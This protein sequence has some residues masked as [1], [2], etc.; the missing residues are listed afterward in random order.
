MEKILGDISQM[1]PDFSEDEINNFLFKIK[2]DWKESSGIFANIILW[3][4]EVLIYERTYFLD[5]K[6]EEYKTLSKKEQFLFNCI[7]TTQSN[8][9]KREK[10]LEKIIYHKNSYIPYFVLLQA[11]SY[12]SEILEKLYNNIEWIDKELFNS[13]IKDNPLF[14][15]RIK[16]RVCSY[17]WEYGRHYS[18]WIKEDYVGFQILKKLSIKR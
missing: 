8:W 15:Q 7:N 13:F 10:S 6:D 2:L 9:Y 4:K 1:F 11:W 16:W 5:D 3:W 17:Y 18:S 14:V 12:V